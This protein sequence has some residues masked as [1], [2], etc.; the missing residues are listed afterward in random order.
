MVAF[1]SVQRSARILR[2]ENPIKV[3]TIDN[4]FVA[5]EILDTFCIVLSPIFTVD[6]NCWKVTSAFILTVFNS[7][8]IPVLTTRNFSKVRAELRRAELYLSNG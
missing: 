7:F 4:M 3:F 1:L 6:I 8:P 2:G 5:V